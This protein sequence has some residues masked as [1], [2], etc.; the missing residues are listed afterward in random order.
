MSDDP[1][2]LVIP[3]EISGD[4]KA[5]ELLSGWATG[6]GK[7]TL[8]TR[9]GTG[10]D[11]SPAIWGEILAA[12]AHNVALSVR[13]VTGADPSLTMAAIKESLDRSWSADPAGSGQHYPNPGQT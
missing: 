10:L 4:P 5:Y 11:Q 7:V 9:T 6:A 8:M 1:R 3:E 13:D 2:R 12:I